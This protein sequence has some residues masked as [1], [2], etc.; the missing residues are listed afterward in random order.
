MSKSKV[1]TLDEVKVHLFKNDLFHIIMFEIDM[2]KM[3]MLPL[4]ILNVIFMKRWI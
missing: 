4:Q 2:E 1:H 3:C